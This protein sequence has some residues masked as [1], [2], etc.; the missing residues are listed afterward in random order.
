MNSVWIKILL[1][2]SLACNCT[3]AGAL[4]YKYFFAPEQPPPMPGQQLPPGGLFGPEVRLEMRKKIEPLRRHIQE[5]RARIVE[6]LRADTPDREKIYRE[7]DAISASQAS[8]QRAV[9]DQLIQDL[10][11]MTPE[12]K[13]AY[14]DAMKD[15]RFWRGVF[16][17]GRGRH[18]RQ[19][20]REAP[21]L[22][23]PDMPPE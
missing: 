6:L 4:T 1:V 20:F 15:Q 10:Q 5:A 23:P 3:I 17:K 22:P 12:Q 14:L 7:I 16:G 21:P 13:T 18:G 8:I 9:M 2:F 19:G 11:R